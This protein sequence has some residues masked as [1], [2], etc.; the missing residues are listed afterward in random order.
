MNKLINSNAKIN[1]NDLKKKKKKKNGKKIAK[2]I[3][4]R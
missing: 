1:Y 2:S 3:F 4:Y